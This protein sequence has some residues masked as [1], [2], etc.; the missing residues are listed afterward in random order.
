M[1]EEVLRGKYY[2]K[3]GVKKRE[4]EHRLKGGELSEDIWTIQF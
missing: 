1:T 3:I 4:F 2:E